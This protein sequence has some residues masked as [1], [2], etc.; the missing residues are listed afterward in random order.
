MNF[1]VDWLKKKKDYLKSYVVRMPLL[2]LNG[3]SPYSYISKV[4]LDVYPHLGQQKV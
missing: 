1:P 4:T 2:H 3:H